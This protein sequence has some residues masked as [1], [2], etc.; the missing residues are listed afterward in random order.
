M[1]RRY[2]KSHSWIEVDGDVATV[3]ITDYAQSELG[4]VAFVELPVVG[5]ALNK[6]ERF[7]VVESVKTASEVYAPLSGTV[8]ELNAD[9]EKTPSLVNTDEVASF[10]FGLNVAY[11]RKAEAL[12]QRRNKRPCDVRVLV[13]Q[14]VKVVFGKAEH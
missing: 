8:V 14:V 11:V 6:G 13:Y 5:G 2:T 7:A 1:E 3:G 10:G 9:L 4:D 12:A